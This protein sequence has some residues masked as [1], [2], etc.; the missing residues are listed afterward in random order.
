MTLNKLDYY[1]CSTHKTKTNVSCIFFLS[2]DHHFD[3]VQLGGYSAEEIGIL[4]RTKVLSFNFFI[5]K[6]DDANL[7]INSF[8]TESYERTSAISVTAS[9][10]RIDGTDHVPRHSVVPL[11]LSH[12]LVTP[13]V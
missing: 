8:L 12:P 3:P 5:S 1:Y 6:A 9:V 13:P 11:L 10:C 4:Q 2:L 7:L